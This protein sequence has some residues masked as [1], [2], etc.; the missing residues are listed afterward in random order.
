MANADFH[1]LEQVEKSR[2]FR[3]AKLNLSNKGGKFIYSKN[4]LLS[5]KLELGLLKQDTAAQT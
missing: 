3:H 2:L 4:T 1:T 5:T